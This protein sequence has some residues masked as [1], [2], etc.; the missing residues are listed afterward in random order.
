MELRILV[1]LFFVSVSAIF[2]AA[3][4]L[5]VYKVFSG[6]TSKVTES[7]A[8]FKKN[9]EAREWI[10][11]MRVAAEQ[12]AAVTESTKVK[13]AEF[14][15]AL[16]RAHDNYRRTLATVDSKLEKF[17]ADVNITAEKVKDV[18]A[19]PAVSVAN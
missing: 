12:A 1:F 11:S 10:E 18:V 9:S 19:K 2:N 4:I 8:A 17:A 3:L 16:A 15:P 7:V 6:L 13:M 5:F 14:E